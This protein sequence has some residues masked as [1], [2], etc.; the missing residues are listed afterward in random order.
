MDGTI[1]RDGNWDSEGTK[2]IDGGGVVGFGTGVTGDGVAGCGVTGTGL[3][4]T[5]TFGDGVGVAMAVVWV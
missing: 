5:V 4:S 1:D 3:G 2:E